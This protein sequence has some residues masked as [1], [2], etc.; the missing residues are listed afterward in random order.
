MPDFTYLLHAQPTTLGHYLLTFAFPLKRD[1]D[2][3]KEMYSRVNSSPGESGSV[4]GSR[5]GLDKIY[6][7]QLLGFENIS[8]HCRDAMWQPDIPL[9][10]ISKVASIL[11][12]IARLA[13]EFQIWN[14]QEFN[15]LD[16]PDSLCRASVIMPQKKNPYPLTYIRGLAN[17]VIS[18][19]SAYGSYGRISSG[20]PDSRIFIYGDLVKTIQKT[21]K[22]LELFTK[23]VNE[24]VIAEDRLKKQVLNS[25]AYATDLADE[26]LKEGNFNYREAHQIVGKVTRQLIDKGLSL[27]DLKQHEL[28]LTAFEITGKNLAFD[29]AKINDLLNPEKIVASRT[30]IGGAAVSEMNKMLISLNTSFRTNKEWANK[31]SQIITKGFNYLNTQIKQKYG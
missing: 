26:I 21:K 1:I 29:Q 9:E 4:N 15:Y 27:T 16:L 25:D 5:L 17:L 10:I 2:R 18:K 19:F 20:N 3:L 13:E 24:I 7:S 22:G 11:M 30:T 12:N 28:C 31:K 6:F 8:T 23:L 14:T